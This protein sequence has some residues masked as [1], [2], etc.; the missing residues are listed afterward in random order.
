ME[1]RT[2]NDEKLY[3]LTFPQTMLMERRKR[4]SAIQKSQNGTSIDTSGDTRH[5]LVRAKVF[6]RPFRRMETFFVSFSVVLIGFYCFLYQQMLS[7]PEVPVSEEMPYR[8]LDHELPYSLVNHSFETVV[9]SIFLPQRPRTFGYYRDDNSIGAE[10]LDPNAVRLYYSH[11]MPD[12]T[13]EEIKKQEKLLDSRKYRNGK[14]DKLE[15]G[16]C[17][18]QYQ[19]QKSFFPTCNFLMEQDLIDSMHTSLLDHG[20]WRDVWKLTDSG[21]ETILKTMRFEHDYTPRNYDRHR[22]DAVAMERLKASPYVLDIYAYCGNSG[23]S[24]EFMF[25]LSSNSSNPFSGLFEYASGGSLSDSIYH[26][27]D[28]NPWVGVMYLLNLRSPF[29]I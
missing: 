1:N 14:A 22:R 11:V 12:I 24:I 20:Y 23:V 2:D 3:H 17:V 21:K 27:Q 18:A 6:R 5:R 13:V 28:G 10:R 16:N 7:I 25:L 15:T 29:P 26:D 9:P 19:W 8:I 4:S